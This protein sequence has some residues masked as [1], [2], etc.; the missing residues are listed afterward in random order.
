[1]LRAKD[2][3]AECVCFDFDESSQWYGWVCTSAFMYCQ[4]DKYI[5]S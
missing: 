5:S 3:H 1:M 2:S 4:N